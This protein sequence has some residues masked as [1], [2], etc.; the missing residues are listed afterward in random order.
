MSGSENEGELEPDRTH[1]TKELK[2][3]VNSFYEEISGKGNDARAT[4]RLC[5]PTKRTIIKGVI[6]KRLNHLCTAKHYKMVNSQNAILSDYMINDPR[7]TKKNSSLSL[8]CGRKTITIEVDIHRFLR[9]FIKAV[10]DGNFS[11]SAGE[12]IAKMDGNA[13]IFKKFGIRMS[14]HLLKRFVHHV[15]EHT[16]KFITLKLA[17]LLFAVVMDGTSR[18]NRHVLG[19]SI[20]YFDPETARFIEFSIGFIGQTESQTGECIALELEKILRRVRNFI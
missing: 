13:L 1:F 20:R 8:L 16:K 10:L 17:G 4:C 9:N 11:F 14:R 6:A 12:D 18:S 19:I 3:A 5:L 7:A 2:D 15:S